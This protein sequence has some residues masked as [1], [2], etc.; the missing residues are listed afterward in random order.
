MK[1][2]LAQCYHSLIKKIVVFVPQFFTGSFAFHVG[3]HLRHSSGLYDER[4]TPGGS[5]YRRDDVKRLVYAQP[6]L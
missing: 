6:D 4:T 1:T 3:D 5:V 2:A